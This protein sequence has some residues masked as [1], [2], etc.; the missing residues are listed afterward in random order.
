LLL[1]ELGS[2][3]GIY[4]NMPIRNLLE[5]FREVLPQGFSQNFLVYFVFFGVHVL[6]LIYILLTRRE[7][8]KRL[9]HGYKGNTW[10]LLILGVLAGLLCNSVG[11][12][13][14]A[15]NGDLTFELSGMKLWTVFVLFFAIFVQSSAEELVFRGYVYQYVRD[16][17][18]VVP[19][20]I[21]NSCIF[22]LIHI[23]NTGI[24]VFSMLNIALFGVA[25]SLA[26]YRLESQWFAAAFHAGWNF[27][28][29]FIFGLPNSGS[30]ATYSILSVSSERGSIFYDKIFGIEGTVSTTVILV[31]LCLI[32]YFCKKKG[33]SEKTD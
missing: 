33:N 17:Y 21:V 18:S 11:I 3:L 28:Q 6:T 22:A 15:L 19:A 12:G 20:I 8:L 31:S 27:C 9:V 24:T 29:A 10:K 4:I 16:S 13:I 30:P 32:L 26:I 7:V 14:A 25:M 5:R 23:F 2:Y 1:T